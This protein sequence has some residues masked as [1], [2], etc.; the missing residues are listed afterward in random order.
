MKKPFSVTFILGILNAER[1][2]KECLEGIYNQNY[3]SKNFEVLIID[4]GSTDQT[5]NIVKDF[6]KKYKNIRLLHNPRKLSEGKGMS[7][8]MGVKAAKGEILIFLD[9]DNI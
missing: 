9:H 3:S 8:D 6:Q 5:L 1:T 4:G 7:K 2:L